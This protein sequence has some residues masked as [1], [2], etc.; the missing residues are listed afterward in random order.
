MIFLSYIIRLIKKFMNEENQDEAT[1]PAILELNRLVEEK[2][3]SPEDAKK[4]SF[5]FKK[6]QDAFT[7]SCNT[8]QILMRRTRNLNKELKAQKLT[9][10]NSAQQQLGH[11]SQL[12]ELRQSVTAMQVDLESLK[13]QIS[14][15]QINTKM[16]IKELEKLDDK[17]SKAQEN[18]RSTLDPQKRQIQEEN[19]SLEEMISQRKD[20]IKNLIKEGQDLQV[21]IQKSDKQIQELDVKKKELNKRVLDISAF[22]VKVRAK[23]Q[24]AENS[25]KAMLNDEDNTIA[26]LK[27]VEEGISNQLNKQREYENEIQHIINDTNGMEDT[28][29]QLKKQHDSIKVETST[30]KEVRL[31]REYEFRTLNKT[32]KDTDYT[33]SVLDQKYN[34]L[35]KEIERKE[36]E[37]FKMQE[38]IA[39]FM[40]EKES[41][42][43]QLKKCKQEADN[44]RQ[45]N[46][47]LQHELDKVVEGR[48][49]AV[50][51]VLALE[52]V[53]AK[54]LDQ[55]K[56]AL[57]IK[58]K[59]QGVLDQIVKKEKDLIQSL[60]ES[61]L[62][63]NR[64]VRELA[65][66][67]K[68]VVDAKTVVSEKNMHYLDLTRKLERCSQILLDV[69]Q[70]Y[71]KA[72]IERNRYVNTI[73]TSQQMTVE[74]K[75]K[76]K[77]LDNEV[78]VLRGELNQVYAAVKAQ[79]FE[80][81]DAFKRKE[82]T[83]C[84]L[85]QEE[86]KYKDLQKQIDYQVSE[87]SRL[88][89]VLQHVEE[90]INQQQGRYSIQADDCAN[91]QRMLIDK[92][93][94]LCIVYEQYNRHEEVMRKGEAIL[95]EKE[96][97]LKILNLQLNDF[98]RK[99]DILQRKIPL[100]RK[101]QD[102]IEE[103][104]IQIDKEQKEVDTLTRK[105]E[106]PDAN[107]RKRQYTG[108]DFSN[109]ELDAKISLY[110]QRVSDKKRTVVEKQII[111]RDI[112]ENITKIKEEIGSKTSP[113]STNTLEKGGNVRANTMKIR[114]KKM[115]ALSE[116]AIY[117]AKQDELQ[118][119]KKAVEDEIREA[120]SRTQRGEAFDEYA[121]KMVRM[122]QRDIR[123]AS[124]PKRRS[125]FDSDDEDDEER[126]PG[127]QKFDAYPTAD[128]LS[129]PY[130]QFPVFQ[131]GDPSPNLRYYKKEDVR[132]IVV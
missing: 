90:L 99:I 70:L 116:M 51:A 67:R 87:T 58:D 57:V 4:L 69:S 112:N 104:Q 117:Q 124:S 55:V 65:K 71:E 10:E 46:V 39:R 110:E 9:I 103:L 74:F 28:T 123:T 91:I 18:Q 45:R 36:S 84:Q 50:K 22:P 94:E 120:G 127:R 80:L 118:E 38:A 105:L 21:R 76:I 15:T 114:R 6:L 128:G 24:N 47:N 77:I 19:A 111:L 78:D 96:E 49:N 3:I 32:I 119:Q 60:K 16:K 88:N 108:R 107:E 29:D 13:D 93:D 30:Q 125:I 89:T 75:E 56:E 106:V 73:Q 12:S 5:R 81:N 20:K 72:K 122:H 95:K 66:V 34:L 44:E 8:E 64:K 97:E 129:R 92:Q 7:Q 48:E 17:V 61:A 101:Y 85:K 37:I 68:K 35:I 82:A 52:S 40:L 132:P 100:L 43:S 131:P 11:R 42:L 53:N 102:D 31:Q 25:L 27:N 62:I 14:S 115:A 59:K 109:N 2:Q 83:K 23:A 121:E 130:G 33:V 113:K 54:V 126:P 63:R 79:K 86:D 1:H 98:A 26:Q 41:M